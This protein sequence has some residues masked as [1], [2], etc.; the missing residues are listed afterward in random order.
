M[1]TSDTRWNV[2]FNWFIGV[3]STLIAGVAMTGLLKAFETTALLTRIQINQIVLQ[4]QAAD[5][6]AANAKIVEQ[7]S[8][9]SQAILS[10]QRDIA[11]GL[12]DRW[13]RN[14]Q[15]LWA[16]ELDK[17]NDNLNVPKVN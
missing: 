9:T 13:T 12:M 11:D 16:L 6:I 1:G 4:Q 8:A 5:A 3:L 7:Q 10:L 17:E 2:A 14:D 15:R